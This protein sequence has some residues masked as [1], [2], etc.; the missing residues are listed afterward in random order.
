MSFKIFKKLKIS[1]LFV[2]I[3]ANGSSDEKFEKLKLALDWNRSD[4]ASSIISSNNAK[5]S[6]VQ[7]NELM[8][9]ALEYN[10]ADFVELILEIQ[11]DLKDFY[12]K[13]NQE[14]YKFSLVSSKIWLQF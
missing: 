8:K 3:K 12:Q 5:L 6:N 9:L 11:I 1:I 4:I 2:A 10:F 7:L 13:Y 14:L